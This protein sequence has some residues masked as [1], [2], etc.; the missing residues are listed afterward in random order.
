[1]CPGAARGD[2]RDTQDFEPEVK[3]LP[4][5]AALLG[6]AS[7]RCRQAAHSLLAVLTPAPLIMLSRRV[8]MLQS[9]TL[10]SP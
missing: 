6:A 2:N 1:M 7:A 4:L 5:R 10:P 9:I 8:S 3:E